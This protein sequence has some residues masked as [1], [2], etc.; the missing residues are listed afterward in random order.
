MLGSLKKFLKMQNVPRVF[1]KYGIEDLWETFT[2]EEK[3]TIAENYK[4]GNEDIYNT[5]GGNYNAFQWLTFFLSYFNTSD[6]HRIQ[7]KTIAYIENKALS[8]IGDLSDIHFYYLALIRFYYRPKTPGQYNKEMAEQVCLAD[9]DL[10]THHTKQFLRDMFPYG[11]GDEIIPNSLAFKTLA[12]IY[13]KD[14]EY[15]KAIDISLKAL[16]LGQ[17]DGTKGGYAGRIKRLQK[18][19]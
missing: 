17:N 14:E 7:A 12:I 3:R 15:E 5:I 9:I 11:Y 4:L 18:K 1:Q 10:M 19:L 2:D 8:Q 16:E 6:F 13:E